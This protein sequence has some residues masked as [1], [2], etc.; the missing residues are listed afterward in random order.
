MKI[1]HYIKSKNYSVEAF[2]KIVGVSAI[3]IYKYTKGER[4]PAP[5]IM[6]KIFTLT[7]GQVTANDFYDLSELP[8][9]RI[10]NTSIS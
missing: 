4:I 7:Q 9:H 3:A 2:A 5:D 10:E 1:E 8:K 6:A